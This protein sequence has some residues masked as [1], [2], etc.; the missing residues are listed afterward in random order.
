MAYAT[1]TDALMQA[2]RAS[3][4]RGTPFSTADTRNLQSSYMADATERA[5]ADRASTLAEDTL[6]SNNA[7][8]AAQ[9]AQEKL[10]TE[11]QISAADAASKKQMISSG[12]GTAASLG[13]AYLM[14]PA[15]AG[16]GAAASTLSEGVA[17][18]VSAG[19]GGAGEGATLAGGG[20]GTAL[21]S[22][23]MAGA[24]AAPAIIAAHYGMPV[25]GG[26]LSRNTPGEEGSSNVFQQGARITEN[27][28]ATPIEAVSR[29]MGVEMPEVA[30]AIFNPGGYLLGKGGTVICTELHRQCLLSNDILKYDSLFRERYISDAEYL[31]YRILAAPVVWLLRKSARFTRFFSPLAV[32]TAT[33]M[34]SRAN[35]TINGTMQGKAVLAVMVPICGKVG[36]VASYFSHPM[37]FMQALYLSLAPPALLMI[38]GR[39]RPKNPGTRP[40]SFWH[41]FS[42]LTQSSSVLPGG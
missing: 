2:K 26:M 15:A 18:G 19:M 12:I 9:L 13:G 21:G 7:N 29:E 42:S 36:R 40:D 24:Y 37:R 38:P 4:L 34:A 27:E 10:N 5:N 1:F 28:W 20:M 32:A 33:E 17:G 16:A 22:V 25:L 30:Q 23:G 41:C 39:V 6:T 35:V 11:A 31:G 8:F 3:Q 14:R